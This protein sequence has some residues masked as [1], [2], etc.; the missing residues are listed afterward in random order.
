MKRF[1]SCTIVARRG[2]LEEPAAKRPGMGEVVRSADVTD[3]P[4]RQALAI[5]LIQAERT[6]DARSLSLEF[7]ERHRA[8]ACADVR[9]DD[10]ARIVARFERADVDRDMR[11]R[12]A[13]HAAHQR[14]RASVAFGEEHV[15]GP[16]QCRQRKH[17]TGRRRAA[18]RLGEVARQ[19]ADE[20]CTEAG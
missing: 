2:E 16:Q 20:A 5:G 7:R 8:N 14:R 12:R 15:T 9:F 17:V 4:V 6:D 19:G 10:A 11:P 1:A 18:D 13:G 3:E